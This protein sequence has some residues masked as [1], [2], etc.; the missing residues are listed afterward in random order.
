MCFKSICA[1]FP[2][3]MR[4]FMEVVYR[5]AN[6]NCLEVQQVVVGPL[7]VGVSNQPRS[8]RCRGPEPEQ[9]HTNAG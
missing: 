3:L 4:Q 8:G 2:S 6:R 9:G 5:C 1:S 7:R